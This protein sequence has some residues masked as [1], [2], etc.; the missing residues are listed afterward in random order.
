MSVT[1]I[2]PGVAPEPSNGEVIE[3][4]VTE[5]EELLDHARAGRIVGLAYAAQHQEKMTTYN[6]C[7]YRSRAVLG[8]LVLLQ[9][10]MARLDV[11]DDE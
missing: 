7:G 10:D 9:H 4:V 6:H 3:S 11:E 8:T 1:P 5:L 2:R